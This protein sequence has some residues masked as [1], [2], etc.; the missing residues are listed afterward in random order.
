MQ[1]AI[2]VQYSPNQ[3]LKIS[4]QELNDLLNDGWI[5]KQTCPMPSSTG[6]YAG[7]PTCL[8]I[9]EIKGE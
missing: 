9:L 2:I 3:S 4:S 7:A 8:V 5:V 6:D 1:K